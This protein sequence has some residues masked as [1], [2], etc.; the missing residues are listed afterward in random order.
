LPDGSGHPRFQEN[1]GGHQR[2]R[3]VRGRVVFD[4]SRNPFIPT[5]YFQFAAHSIIS[6]SDGKLFPFIRHTDGK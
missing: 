5:P 4:L 2:A 1:I 6:T 3:P